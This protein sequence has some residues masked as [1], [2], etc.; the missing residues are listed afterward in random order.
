MS[1]ESQP[2]G[3][4]APSPDKTVAPEPTPP[5]ARSRGARARKPHWL[6]VRV[7]VIATAIIG[8]IW[9]AVS[10]SLLD[11][12][13]NYVATTLDTF[14][15]GEEIRKLT[16]DLDQARLEY[17]QLSANRGVGE[18]A[19][20]PIPF[21]G[22]TWCYDQVKQWAQQ[23]GYELHP[24]GEPKFLTAHVVYYDRMFELRC[25]GM[26]TSNMS[27]LVAASTLAQHDLFLS[28]FDDL[29]RYFGHFGAYPEAVSPP[30]PDWDQLGP[31][32]QTGYIYVDLPYSELRY[33]NQGTVPDRITRVV[34]LAGSKVATRRQGDF[35]VFTAND[36][37]STVSVRSPDP[38]GYLVQ[39]GDGS[40]KPQAQVLA[41]G[42]VPP[43][44]AVVRAPLLVV[45]SGMMFAQDNVMTGNVRYLDDDI[46]ARLG[47]IPGV[48]NNA[49]IDVLMQSW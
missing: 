26:R 27:Y 4:G 39:A 43:D 17:N 5:P 31:F 11:S 35:T 10:S 6:L 38:A 34:A 30:T 28:L 7:G 14:R 13:R 47:R 37:G 9:A 22:A 46:R 15:R 48:V 20:L 25:Y 12:G 33:W 41:A 2:S 36:P 8:T 24:Y 49:T 16:A 1:D 19:A 42:T 44:S 3:D 23:K 40:W 21:R 32:A 18:T 45:I 29:S